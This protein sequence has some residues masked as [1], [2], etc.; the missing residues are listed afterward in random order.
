M[1]Y[2]KVLGFT[3]DFCLF[4]NW[5]IT[6]LTQNSSL[7]HEQKYHCIDV[8]NTVLEV[9]DSMLITQRAAE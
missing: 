6:D 8:K 1:S 4:V 2:C 9:P 7:I 3:M 5:Y